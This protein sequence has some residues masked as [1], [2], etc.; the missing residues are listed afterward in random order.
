MQIDAQ[1]AFDIR[2]FEAVANRNRKDIDALELLGG[3]YSK[4]GMANQSLRIDRR[5]ARIQPENAR[6]Q[7][8]LACSL[9]LLDRKRDAVKALERAFD[10]GYDDFTWMLQDPDL[11]RLRGFAEFEELISS[12]TE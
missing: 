1:D 4:Y 9:C 8:N 2:F 6:I 3:L 11:E 10:L 7:Y 12:V 5:L